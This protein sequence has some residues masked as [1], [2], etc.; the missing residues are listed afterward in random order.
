M[1]SVPFI[2]LLSKVTSDY[3]QRTT[4]MNYSYSAAW[5]FGTAMTVAMYVWWLV[6]VVESRAV[7]TGCREEGLLLSVLSFIGKVATGVGVWVGGLML[8]LI[9][10]PAD[11]LS[12]ELP[13]EV[14][15]RLGWLYGPTLAILYVMAIAALLFSLSTER[16]KWKIYGR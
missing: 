5:F 12:V 15:T 16:H 13:A 8:A 1:H 10:F 11:A 14:V 3:D 7:A 9:D 2:A 6:N 4:L